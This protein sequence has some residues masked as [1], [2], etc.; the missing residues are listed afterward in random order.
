MDGEFTF[1]FAAGFAT[2]MVLGLLLVLTTYTSTGNAWRNESVG[3]G[4]AHYDKNGM[5]HWNA[6]EPEKK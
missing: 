3:R 6:E 5:W 2:A 4:A 1:G